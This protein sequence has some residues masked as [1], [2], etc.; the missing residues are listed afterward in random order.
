MFDPQYKNLDCIWELVGKE[1]TKI[2]VYE[3][4]KKIMISLLVKVN[5]F[6]NPIGGSN[7]SQVVIYLQLLSFILLC[8][9]KKLVGLCLFL[10]D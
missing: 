7:N 6:F 5:H 2:V 4:D 10:N 8:W 1:L 9:L 3:C